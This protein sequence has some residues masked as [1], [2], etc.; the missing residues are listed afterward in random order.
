MRTAFVV[1]ALAIATPAHA[2]Q[3][4]V[5]VTGEA[6]LQPQV[7]SEVEVWLH[8]RGRTIA[9]AALDPSAVNTLIDCFVLEDIGCARGLIDARS[10]ATSVI[11][12]RIDATQGD[13][14]TR[15][16][17]VVGTWFQKNH[18]SMSERRLCDKCTDEK[19][20]TTIDELMLAL[21]HQ[22]PLPAE[23]APPPAPPVEETTPVMPVSEGQP[24]RNMLPIGLAAA[25]AAAL[26]TG[27]VLVAIDEDPSPTGPQQP[28]YRDSGTAGFV[29]GFA[30]AAMIGTGVYLWLQDRKH[31]APV[32]SV[33][34]DGAVVG[35]TGRF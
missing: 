6:T 32:A 4:G 26:L 22:P 11:Y 1:L 33:T 12:A 24:R 15:Q 29:I 35:W 17:E 7:A 19:L 10:K 20:H 28:S 23:S 9:P 18:E 30:G 34:H 31:G 8:A 27:G 14:G 16:V 3:V 25:G 21:V 2:E 5:V 13:D